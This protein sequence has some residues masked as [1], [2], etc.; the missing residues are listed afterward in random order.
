MTLWLL[1]L[2]PLAGAALVVAAARVGARTAARTRA[3]LLGSVAVGTL[4]VTLLAALWA[5]MWGQPADWSWWGPQLRPYLAVTGLGRV[6][7]VLVPVIAAPVVG[8]AAASMR[9]DPGLPRL[10]ALLVAFTGAMELLVLAGDFLTLLVAWELVG[11]CSWALIGYDWRDAARPR[12]ARDAFLTT[13]TGDLGLYLAAAAAFAATGSVRFDALTGLA[14]TDGAL[15]PALHVVAAG[16]VL[17]AAAK[18]AQLPFAPW[19]FSAMAGPTAAS[20]LLH[21]ATMV[22]AGAYLLA[23]L[24]PALAPTNWFGPTG[25]GLGLATAL[26]GGVVA[27]LQSDLKKALAA[28]TSAQYGLMLVAIGAGFTGAAG[29]HLIAHAAFK[30][31]LFL[32]AGIALHVAGTL[33][34][35]RLRLGR[36]LPRAAALFAIGAL[37][38][39]AVPPLGAAYSKEQIVAAAVHAPFGRWWLVPGVFAAALLSAFY[40]GRLYLL[41]FG[42]TDGRPGAPL[43]VSRPARIELASVGVLAALSV[44]LGLLWVPAGAQLAGV[45]IGGRV[46]EGSAWELAASF[47]A[48]VAAAAACWALWRRGALYTLGLHTARREHVAAWFG[49]PR[50]AQ[51]AVIAPSLALARMLA[52]FDERVVDAGIRAAARIATFVSRAAAWWGERGVDG[53]VT[54]IVRATERTALGSRVA[55]DRAIDGTV[56]GIGRGVGAA[57]RQSR[58][59]QTGLA[60]HY[61]VVVA[62]GALVIAAAAALGPFLG[63]LAVGR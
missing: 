24:A 19:L 56:E 13:R 28:S 61:Y 58:R 20:A 17:A 57:G 27:S 38:L 43:G 63:R 51:A 18:S 8:Y 2:L 50:L 7:V 4:L 22:A 23:R 15:T 47:A 42:P 3:T 31:L 9:T 60:H 40:A 62:V 11:A 6:M 10:L 1:P 32:G 21:S 34:L 14:G 25:A 48:I 5:A 45:A 12:A 52:A 54:A 39:A 46:A 44:G 26:A 30:A 59:L 41:A 36:A 37:A 16:V 35:D 29:L 33:D 49:L 53:V 55:D